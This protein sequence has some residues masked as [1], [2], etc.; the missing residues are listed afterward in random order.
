MLRSRMVTRPSRLHRCSRCYKPMPGRG[1]LETGMCGDCFCLH[2]PCPRG[3]EQG[4]IWLSG[5]NNRTG[6]PIRFPIA[7]P[8]CA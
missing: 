8:A 1:V 2:P 3:C 5:W 4:Q 7:C 6:L